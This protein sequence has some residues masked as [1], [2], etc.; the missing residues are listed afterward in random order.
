MAKGGPRSRSGP[1]PDP[2]ALR[3]DRQTDKAGWV[4]LPV[5]GRPGPT[6][7]W[8]LA[9]PLKRELEVWEAL[10]VL[11]QAV[12]WERASQWFEVAL[13]VRSFVAA[14]SA[15]ATAAE[16]TLV[17]QQQEALGLSQPGLARNH[18]R[19]GE[20]TATAAA[21]PPSPTPTK[22]PPRRQTTPARD[23]LR[24]VKSA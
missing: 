14:E 23:R 3:R 6:P 21:P 9:D 12:E 17:R 19:I 11:P 10:W 20:D 2:N 4:V 16:R 13:H 15:K 7:A 18:W 8:P 24:V 22:A 5:E 1:P